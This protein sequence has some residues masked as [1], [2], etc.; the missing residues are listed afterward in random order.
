M[1]FFAGLRGDGGS[2]MT[3][4]PTVGRSL[5]GSLLVIA[6]LRILPDFCDD[7]VGITNA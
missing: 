5:V 3:G 6:R 7:F 4:L 2:T 1:G